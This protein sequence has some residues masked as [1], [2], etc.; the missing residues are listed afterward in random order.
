M[1]WSTYNKTNERGVPYISVYYFIY[2]P[3]LLYS[4]SLKQLTL[5]NIRLTLHIGD[6]STDL[7]LKLK[8][9]VYNGYNQ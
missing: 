6:D 8:V 3:I 5:Y 2:R 9:K 4:R 7:S 1:C